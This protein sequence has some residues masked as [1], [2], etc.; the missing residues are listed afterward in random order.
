MATSES[1]GFTV[2]GAITCHRSG[3]IYVKLLNQTQFEQDIAGKD[4]PAPFALK[5]E[6]NSNNA[7]KEKIPFRFFDVPPGMYAISCFQDLNGNGELDMGLFGPVEPWGMYRV[8]PTF[9]PVF[10]KE[11]YKINGDATGISIEVK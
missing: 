10:A 2:E 6:A 1:E 8:K 4:S 3:A 9:K 11:A 7:G 5:L